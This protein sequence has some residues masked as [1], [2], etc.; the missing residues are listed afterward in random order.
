MNFEVYAYRN[1][2]ELKGVFNA[3]AALMGGADFLGLMRTL[4]LVMI[5]SL[6]L[7]VL[8]GRGRMENFWQWVFMVAILHGVLF[9]PKTNVIFVDRTGSQPTQV[10]AN[11]PIGLAALAHTVS[12]IGDWTTRAFETVFSLPDDIKFQSSGMMFGQR[13]QQEMR[14]LKIISS[15]LSADFNAWYR[16]CVVPEIA[17]T[18]GA[19]LDDVMQAPDAWAALNGRTNPALYVTISDT[20]MN[21]QQAYDNLTQRFNAESRTVLDRFATALLPGNPAAVTKVSNVINATDSLFLGI[22]RSA[23]DAI[24]QGIVGMALLDAHCNVFAESNNPA[25]A[26][27]C[28]AQVSSIRSANAAYTVMAKVAESSMPKLRNAIELVQY[29]IAPIILLIAVVSGHYAIRVLRTYAMSLVW[30]QPWPPLYAVVHYIMTVKARQLAQMT[31]SNGG[32]MEWLSMIDGVMMSDQAVAGMLVVAIPPIAAALVKGGEVG[33]QA[34]AGLVTPPR[35]A[36]KEA[37]EIARGNYTAGQI[38]AAPTVNYAASPTPVMALRGADGSYTYTHPDGSVTYSAATAMDKASFKVS[39]AGR[40]AR[41][42]NKSS[43]EAETAA[44]GEVVSATKTFGTAI[45]R[46]I[47]FARSHLRETGNET[48]WGIDNA[49]EVAKAAEEAK[50]IQDNYLKEHGVNERLSAAIK[51]TAAVIAQT[52]ELINKVSPVKLK[53]ELAAVLGSETDAAY[54]A[55][56][57]LDLARTQGY[58]EA[59]R[60]VARAARSDAFSEAEKSSTGAKDSVQ[61]LTTE[62]LQ[63]MEQASA[64]IQRSLAYRELASQVKEHGVTVDQDLTTRVM[65]RLMKERAT[66]DGHTYNGFRKEEVDALM[67]QNNPEMRAMVERIADEETA[68]LM[69]EKFGELKT[70][71]DVRKFFERGKAAIPGAD[72][73]AAQGKQWL[74]GVQG[75]AAHAGVDPRAG[76]GSQLPQQVAATQERAEQAIGAGRGQVQAEGKPLE[77]R[78]RNQTAPGTQPLLGLAATNAAAQILPDGASRLM[79]EKLPGV[80]MSVGVPG[81]AVAE[82]AAERS[83]QGHP[84]DPVKES[85]LRIDDAIDRGVSAVLPGP[86]NYVLDQAKSL[87]EQKIGEMVGTQQPPVQPGGFGVPE[88]PGTGKT[89]EGSPDA[90]RRT[91]GHGEGV[92]RDLLNDDGLPQEPQAGPG[93]PLAGSPGQSNLGKLFGSGKKP[94]PVQSQPAEGG[95]DQRKGDVPPPSNR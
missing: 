18:N 21:C 2:E 58:S 64:S 53:G 34:V 60:T 75:A 6:A 26:A 89:L 36:E 82:A 71:E 52:P 68:A 40:E 3:V 61:A 67:R 56:H 5:L 8:A 13:V 50:R 62:G 41:S 24:R 4:A 63:R 23:V 87:G 19:I 33:L 69:K 80:N 11:V 59:V 15:P 14:F 57:A 95:G 38:N 94:A 54:V 76:V 46:G 48:R 51:G 90:L 27:A 20:L 55:K 9:V 1:I 43:G 93:N 30:I 81:S 79:M 10:V 73:V 25:K 42:L 92:A 85:L 74:G 49:A 22:S 12:K 7:V 66:I 77:D 44:A 37:A 16:E 70:P 35:S 88:Q 17:L 39:S 84:R 28:L 45:Q 65:N 31:Q 83:R 29:A 86:V 72:D 78:V 91:W 47:E 32:A